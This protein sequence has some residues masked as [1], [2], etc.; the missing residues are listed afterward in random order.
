MQCVVQ[1]GDPPLTL[2]WLKDD[3]RISSELGIQIS[4]DDYS[5]TLAIGRVGS[6]H[7]GEY[8]CIAS[9]PAKTTKLTSR[10]IVSGIVASYQP[11]LPKNCLTARYCTC[12]FAA[13]FRHNSPFHTRIIPPACLTS[14]MCMLQ[15]RFS[16][17]TANKWCDGSCP[18]SM[19]KSNYV[20]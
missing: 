7:A 13:M 18:E 9:N 4:N 19:G 2:Q 12:T 17:N 14:A 6:E 16:I 1:A 11:S 15:K 10:L 5:S 20:S 3:L 8:T